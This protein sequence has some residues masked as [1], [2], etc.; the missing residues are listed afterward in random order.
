[1]VQVYA[2]EC[3]VNGFVYV[4]CTKYKLNK[5][6]REHRCLLKKRRH[7]CP[8]M[9]EDW[10]RYGD[11]VFEIRVLEGLEQPTIAEKR[12]A[13]T[14]WMHFYK[15]K[16]L[17]YNENLASFAPKPEVIAKGQP[18]AVA[19]AGRK[20]T[21][22]ANEKRRL[23]QLGKPKGHGAKVSATKKALG[24]RPS[25]EAARAGGLAAAKLG[26][27]SHAAKIG[28]AKRKAAKLKI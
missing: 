22:E 1:M 19:T 4:G 23:A 15:A 20:W 11:A 10:H 28:H 26:V 18:V 24:Q 13:E 6:M 7:A 16:G 3:S 25:P 17:L 14:K 9:I 21:P 27:P 5:R 2:I 12:A 8:K